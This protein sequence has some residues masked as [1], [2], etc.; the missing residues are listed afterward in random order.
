MSSFSELQALYS[1]SLRTPWYNARLVGN[2]AVAQEE[3]LK[4][5]RQ[6][7]NVE[8]GGIGGECISALLIGESGAGK[9]FVVYTAIDKLREEG[10]QV[11]PVTLHGNSCL[12]DKSAMRQIFTQLQRYLVGGSSIDSLTRATF[13]QG[14]LS[15][16]CVR[17][18]RLLQECT[19]SDHLV[20]ITLEDF[21]MFCHTKSKQSL[22]YNLFDL[23]HLPNTRFVV[24]GVTTR[25]DVTELLEKR[26]KSRFQLRKIVISNPKSFD[27]LVETIECVLCPVGAEAPKKVTGRKTKPV[28]SYTSRIHDVLHSRELKQN[29]SFFR[30]LGYSTREFATAAL[31]ALIQCDEDEPDIENSL[32]NCVRGMEK[33][34]AGDV[35]VMTS[36]LPA[37]TLRDHIVLISLLKLHQDQKKPKSF[38]HVLKQIGSFEKS[39][40]ISTICKHSAKAYWHAFQGLVK[41]GLIEMVDNSQYGVPPPPKFSKCRLAV[42]RSYAA[43]FRDQNSFK[44]TGL[45]NVPTEVHQ[46]ANRHKDMQIES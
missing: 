31:T 25:P 29:W 19:R 34:L 42:T 39:T 1:I 44:I 28:R 24:L 45:D 13:H 14:S 36:L 5:I 9:S 18:A 20:V 35:G 8:S 12:D 16:W 4:L 22:L 21:D 3:L 26:I 2:A 38:A 11:I 32:V 15:E 23:M 7:G 43:L 40:H 33:H 30:D 46:W 10:N 6:S 17:L 41:L 27:D 37:L